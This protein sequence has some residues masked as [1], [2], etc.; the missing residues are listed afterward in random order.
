MPVPL[1][2]KWLV[3]LLLLLLGVIGIFVFRPS[4]QPQIDLAQVPLEILVRADNYSIG[5]DTA[6]VTIV[7]FV[8]LQC[9]ACAY[10]HPI[11]K[12]VTS[13]YTGQV[14]FVV[15]HW[16]LTDQHRNAL[17]A[18][19]AAEAA[20]EEGMFWQMYDILLSRQNEWAQSNDPWPIFVD[21]AG[22][23]NIDRFPTDFTTASSQFSA[24]IE[25]DRT[26]ALAVLATGVPSFF[27]NG[28]FAGYVTSFEQFQGIIESELGNTIRYGPTL[29]QSA[30]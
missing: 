6:P 2:G 24:K 28:K 26:D 25:R 4:S 19:Y 21:Y 20:G 8:D 17:A 13:E 3:I 30:P 15:R 5:L 23:L 18:A 1:K 27:V 9:E 10:V 22:E 7:E 16:P 12:R 11:T 29:P 14:R